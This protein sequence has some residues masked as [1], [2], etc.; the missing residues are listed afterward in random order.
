MIGKIVKGT[1][2][3]SAL[4]YLVSGKTPTSGRRGVII[5]SNMAGNTPRQ[6]ASEFGAFRKLRPTLG[7]AVLHVSLSP[8]PQDR[9]LT[10]AE[11]ADIG[12]QYLDGMGFG[13]CPFVIVRHDDTDHQHIHLLASR[14]TTSGE[15]VSDKQDFKRSEALIHKL[16]TA[17]GLAAVASSTTTTT[18][19]RNTMHP[20][21]RKNIEARLAQSSKEAEAALTDAGPAWTCEP[22]APTDKDR[23]GY[24]RR[25]LEDEYQHEV[26][27]ALADDCA[28][29]K[30]GRQG[31][32]IHTRDGGLIV[33]RGDSITATKMTD[34][35]AASRMVALAVAK[36]WL[37]I[38]VSGSRDFVR[39]AMRTAIRAGLAVHPKDT[40]QRLVLEE[41]MKEMGRGGDGEHEINARPSFAQRLHERRQ[42]ATTPPPPTPGRSPFGGGR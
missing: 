6:L 28:F 39:H 34:D 7:K 2:F 15:V 23:K 3:R 29:I 30:R 33:D 14:I 18:K 20:D 42:Q 40:D 36:G 10:D 19:R 11:F 5:G 25:L 24:K 4:S 22:F 35:S 38:E 37:G 26:T 16:E 8:S 9:R 27:A 12:Q 21:K 13:D 31:L 17:F 41:L 32:M 1:S